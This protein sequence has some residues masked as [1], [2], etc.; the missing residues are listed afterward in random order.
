MNSIPNPIPE[1][2]QHFIALALAPKVGPVLFKAIV[3]YAGSAHA[4]FSF[5]QAQV[6]KIPR[7][8]R[9][10]LEIRQ[11]RESLLSKAAVLLANQDKEGYRLLTALDKD[12]PNRLKANSD[13]PVLLFTKGTADLNALRTVG[14]VGT[15]SATPY[16]KAITKKICED[17]LPYQPSIVSGLAYG[18]DIEA[19][20]AA[21]NLG[22]PTIAVLGSPIHLI[23]PAAHQGTA[24]QLIQENGS[25]LSEYGPGSRMLP[26]NFPARNRIIALLSDALLVVEA[27]EKG[28]ALITAELAF[29]Y[30]K[31]VFAVPGNL[32]AT[33]SEGCNQLI[34]KMKAAIYTGPE[35]LAEA[36]HWSKPGEERM[37]KPLPDFSSREEEEY[38]ILTHLQTK[39]DTEL[40]QLAHVLQIPLG[41]LSSK[42]LSLE[43]EGI[44]QSL[45][46][47]KYKLL[48]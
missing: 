36:L 42:L 24:A 23:Y 31:E 13:A 19:H 40:D 4:F 26:G 30:Q 1:D 28:G 27:A 5:T 37:P 38:K 32:Q 15:R 9:R 8:G 44:I 14:I 10:L 22:L 47:K 16:G 17:L 18:I 11:Q 46:G 33:F 35:D 48:G 43:F 45:P 39:G 29:G 20:R 7:I 25:M 12:F 41:M 21:L 34:R 2:K 6:A 3:A